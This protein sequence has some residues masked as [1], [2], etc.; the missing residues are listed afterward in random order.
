M[1]VTQPANPP[2]ASI[3]SSLYA[4]HFTPLCAFIRKRMGACDEVPD[5][6]Q[7]AFCEAMRGYAGFSGRSAVQTWLYGIA[8][9]VMRSHLARARR[10]EFQPCTVEELEL[11]DTAQVPTDEAL[12]SRQQLAR[13][14]ALL[15]H[16]C[17][18]S[19]QA[20]MLVAVDGLSCEEA[21]TELNVAV[22]TVRSRVSRLRSELRSGLALKLPCA[23]VPYGHTSH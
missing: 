2:V 7:Q 20:L 12:A 18:S 11:A 17:D 19:R 4:A 21:A 10:A 23:A 6:V 15:E 5:I 8:L 1:H 9:N 3:M 14:S 16:C 22:G 13:V